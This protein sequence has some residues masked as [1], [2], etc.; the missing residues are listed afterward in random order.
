MV[1]ETPLADA[2]VSTYYMW[3]RLEKEGFEPAEFAT[4]GPALSGKNIPLPIAGSLPIGMIPVTAQPS[5]IGPSN[6]MP[7]SSSEL[8]WKIWL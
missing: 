5:W 6:I 3:V 8:R 7:L 1:G 4:Y 2:R